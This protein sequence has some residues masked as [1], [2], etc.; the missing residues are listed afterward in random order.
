MIFFLHENYNEAEHEKLIKGEGL[1]ESDLNTL[2]EGIC[3]YLRKKGFTVKEGDDI[4]KKFKPGYQNL[5]TFNEEHIS[6]NKGILLCAS[7]GKEVVYVKCKEKEV[8]HRS[9]I[10]YNMLH[11]T[12]HLW[13]WSCTNTNSGLKQTGN[14]AWK[15]GKKAYDEPEEDEE[16]KNKIIVDIT[17]YEVEAT[18]ISLMNLELIYLE[19]DLSES[20]K[21]L[22]SQ[23]Y[24]YYSLIDLNALIQYFDLNVH[25]N[26][27][28]LNKPPIRKLD[29]GYEI[30]IDFR[31][32]IRRRKK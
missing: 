31:L 2:L 17:D 13:Q 22:F 9:L 6:R 15:L 20:F 1:A 7:N 24:R 29:I 3:S 32:K 8:C 27:F 19:C 10:V 16:I 30:N 25:A 12:G 28:K 5:T 18:A 4:P 23:C 11:M 26:I 21:E 14:A